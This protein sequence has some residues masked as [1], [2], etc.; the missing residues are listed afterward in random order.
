M[1]GMRLAKAVGMNERRIATL[2][3]VWSGMAGNPFSVLRDFHADGN[4]NEEDA[5][6]HDPRIERPEELRARNAGNVERQTQ[7]HRGEG[8][9]DHGIL[10]ETREHEGG[11]A[12]A[13]AAFCLLLGASGFF[14]MDARGFLS[15]DARGQGKAQ[16]VD[17]GFLEQLVEGDEGESLLSQ[18]EKGDK[19]A[20]ASEVRQ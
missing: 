13:Q 2:K 11:A 20:D 14:Y 16:A 8:E 10:E 6:G 15:L 19:A 18:D 17:P 7:A 4:E 12:R 9:K 5:R 1:G 3:A